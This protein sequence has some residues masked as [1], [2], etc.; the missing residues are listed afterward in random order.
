MN[1]ND[2]YLINDVFHG[3]LDIQGRFESRRRENFADPV[4]N[5]TYLSGI[6]AGDNASSTVEFHL[7]PLAARWQYQLYLIVDNEYIYFW[8][9]TMRTQ[10]FKGVTIYQPTGYYNMSKIVAMFDSGAGVEVSVFHDQ[11]TAHVFLPV[12]FLVSTI[13]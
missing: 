10:N 13:I 8:D 5:G 12:E 7:R 11:L 3:K 9:E 6:A 1:N 2:K 4:M